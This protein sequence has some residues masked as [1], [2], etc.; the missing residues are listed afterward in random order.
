[1]SET[2]LS[3]LSLNASGVLRTEN[4][5]G[6][7]GG[8][9]FEN[10]SLDLSYTRDGANAAFSFD[11]SFDRTE[12]DGFT[13]V[14]GEEIG[15][16]DLIVDTGGTRDSYRIGTTLEVG[17]QAPLGFILKLGRQGTIYSGTTDP[18]LF[19]RT[20]DSATITTVLRFS[21]VTE[22]RVTLN[23]DH[24][25]AEDAVKTT[26][27]TR[28]LRFGVTHALSEATVF[29]AS[30]GASEIDDSVDG[31][32][33]GTDVALSLTHALPQG[34][35]SISMN[36]ELT[37][38]R[39]RNTLEVERRFVFPVGTL[40]INLGASD[41]EGT[42]P[43]ITGGLTYSHKLPTGAFTASLSR[44]VSVNSDTN[45]QKTTYATLGLSR[46]LNAVSSVAFNLDYAAVSDAGG[47]GIT[48][49]ERGT[50]SAT[51]RRAL[52]EDWNLSA[53][54]QR[55]YLAEAGTGAAWDNA[56]F[57]TVN[58]EFSWVP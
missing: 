18:G 53:G 7:G 58:R 43:Q 56:V 46:E 13:L 29:N 40:D 36:H 51:Y 28:R 21:P 49:S 39:R 12:V 17:T 48:G 14:A 50:F 34:E 2:P 27:D 19:D 20:T 9:G 22:G 31:V 30:L 6:T 54:Y 32:S 45:V 8:T 42:N 5:P 10:P 44:N 1:L 16:T 23:T 11:A 37:T 3:A 47:G 25:D 41:G 55:R 38:A 26:R 15:V 33:H 4:A 35:I 57:L 52:T 24:Y